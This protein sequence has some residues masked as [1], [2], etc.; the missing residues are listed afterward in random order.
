MAKPSGCTRWSRVPV[1]AQV[2]AILPVFCGISGLTSTIFSMDS[3]RSHPCPPVGTGPE[4]AGPCRPFPRRAPNRAGVWRNT[5]KNVR[6]PAAHTHMP[7]SG[8]SHF[9]VICIPIYDILK[10]YF[11]QAQIVKKRLKYLKMPIRLKKQCKKDL[12]PARPRREKFAPKSAAG[13]GQCPCLNV[14]APCRTQNRMRSICIRHA[15]GW[16]LRAATR[17]LPRDP[18]EC[19]CRS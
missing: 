15:D 1:T 5:A 13:R 4:N 6:S 9:E 7:Q 2:R 12:C 18:R 11:F 3:R 16:R 19:A 14:F 8:G 10:V 17:V